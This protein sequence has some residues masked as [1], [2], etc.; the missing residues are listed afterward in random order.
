MQS[1]RPLVNTKIMLTNELCV[2]QMLIFRRGTTPS[3]FVLGRSLQ[4]DL[5]AGEVSTTGVHSTRV[6]A[7]SPFTFL[8]RKLV[9]VAGIEP[10]H[11]AARDF[12]SLVSTYFTTLAL[13]KHITNFV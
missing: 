10:A 7:H 2:H 1:H 13:F 6:V 4:H 11:L 12:K 9:R 5:L 3:Y 8:A